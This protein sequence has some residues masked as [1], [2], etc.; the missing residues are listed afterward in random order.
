MNHLDDLSRAREGVRDPDDGLLRVSFLHMFKKY[1][2]IVLYSIKRIE[3]RGEE[4]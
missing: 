2:S 1:F 4:K 3:G